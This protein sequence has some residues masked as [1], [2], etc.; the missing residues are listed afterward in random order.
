MFP[1]LFHSLLLSLLTK[2]GA[3]VSSL[4]CIGLCKAYIMV[5]YLCKTMSFFGSDYVSLLCKAYIIADFEL[6][7]FSCKF[8]FW[9]YF[10]VVIYFVILLSLFDFV[11]F[12][13]SFLLCCYFAVFIFDFVLFLVSLY[14]A[15]LV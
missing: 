13:V 7:L 4:C 1:P 14:L 2:A 3:Y 8:L 6:C 9:F 11:L 5:W 12:L 15:L 10:F